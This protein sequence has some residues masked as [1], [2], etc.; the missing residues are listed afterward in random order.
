MKSLVVLLAG[1]VLVASAWGVAGEGDL[2]RQEPIEVKVS[3]G[4]KDGAFTFEPNTLTF[5]TG[6][7]YKLVLSNPSPVKHY[8]TS[9]EFA[10]KVFTRK[11]QVMDGDRQA[12]EIKGAITEIEVFPGGTTEWWF[13]PVQT[14]TMTDLH[15]HVD[16]EG[17]ETH[18]SQ[19]MV[20]K[21]IIK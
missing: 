15:C 12:A 4:T 16:M 19:G 14:G 20:G 2:T 11:V 3:L 7:L 13:V 9:Y 17:G 21:I 6:K 10:R 1:L 18:A 8:F 5:E